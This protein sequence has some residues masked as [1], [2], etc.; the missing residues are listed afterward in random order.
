M[1]LVREF[2]AWPCWLSC[3]ESVL[4]LLMRA[5]P[6]DLPT[7]GSPSL[8]SSSNEVSC[9]TAPRM[10]ERSTFLLLAAG[11]R[12]TLQHSEALHEASGR[13]AGGG[14]TASEAPAGGPRGLPVA[15]P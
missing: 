7:L 6:N 1:S 15:C 4:C 9:T 12:G 5:L 14:A 8:L 2:T 3:R 13:A 10:G 11:L